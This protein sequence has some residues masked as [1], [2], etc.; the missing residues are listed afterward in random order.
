MRPMELRTSLLGLLA[1][2]PLFGGCATSA[3][4][5]LSLTENNYANIREQVSPKQSELAWAQIPWRPSFHAGVADAQV[6]GK[7]VL[8]WVMNGH[9]LGCT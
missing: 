8:L 2:F 9:P 1:F 5:E 4:L 6:Q 3:P 7:P